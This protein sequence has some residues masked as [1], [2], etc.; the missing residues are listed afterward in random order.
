MSV[1]D[2]AAK[3]FDHIISHQTVVAYI[4]RLTE[5]HVT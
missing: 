4:L 1:S 2:K 3:L 5:A